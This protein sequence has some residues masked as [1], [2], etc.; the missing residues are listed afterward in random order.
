MA[1]CAR[2]QT[3]W[4][5]NDWRRTSNKTLRKVAVRCSLLDECLRNEAIHSFRNWRYLRSE[6]TAGKR[7]WKVMG[8]PIGPD[9]GVIY[10]WPL[11]LSV[12]WDWGQLSSREALQN[13]QEYY[14]FIYWIKYRFYGWVKKTRSRELFLGISWYA[15]LSSFCVQTLQITLYTLPCLRIIS[16]FSII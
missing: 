15:T 4:Y 12:I 14:L 2:Q 11:Y 13:I 3:V 7:S 9:A 8:R 1:T 16:S 6:C 10:S 5:T